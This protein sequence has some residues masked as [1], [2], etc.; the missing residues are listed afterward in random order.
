MQDAYEII[1]QDRPEILPLLFPAAIGMGTQ[2]YEAG[3]AT[4][5]IVPPQYDVILKGGGL[6]HTGR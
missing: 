1:K 2:T 3:E 4:A 5:R 6:P